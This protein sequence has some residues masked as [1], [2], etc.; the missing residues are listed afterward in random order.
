MSKDAARLSGVETEVLVRISAGVLVLGAAAIHL[1][2]APIHFEDAALYGWFFL[3][4]GTAQLV[5]GIMLL[6]PRSRGFYL[7]VASFSLSIIGL[8][9]ITRT[10]GVPV[11]LR[12][13]IVE[14]PG[15]PDLTAAAFEL[16]AAALLLGL[17]SG[18]AFPA[19]AV[20][21]RAAGAL[22][23]A[24]TA[25]TAGLVVVAERNNRVICHHHNPDFGP[26]AALEGHSILPQ[27]RPPVSIQMG[28][29]ALVL[30][31]FLINCGNAPVEVT[32]AEPL[33]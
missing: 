6:K 2:H 26:L 7:A 25:A 24:V 3:L 20:T 18:R 11:G 31:G 8:W 4:T 27:G 15:A 13:G 23:L 9:A 22:V 29:K 30:S 28:R 10:A 14:P 1:V 33:S 17:A 21:A 32:G 16:L 5:A 12:A 19:L